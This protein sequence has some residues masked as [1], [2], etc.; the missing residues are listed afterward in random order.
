L[1]YAIGNGLRVGEGAVGFAFSD[2]ASHRP[3]RLPWIVEAELARVDKKG[4]ATALIAKKT[5]YIGTEKLDDLRGQRFLVSGHP[6]FYKVSLV[7]RKRDGT[8]LARYGEYYRVVAPV[9]AVREA[10]IP[11]EVVPGETVYFR[12]ENLGTEGV[13]VDGSAL[14]EQL[15]EGRW[16]E[17]SSVIAEGLHAGIK[18][19]LSGG[20]IAPCFRYSVPPDQQ[21][22]E[23]RLRALVTPLSTRRERG[24]AAEYQVGPRGPVRK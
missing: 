11:T 4:K 21:P 3:R 13:F 7:I 10:V 2:Q 14:I 6:A 19:R 17:V 12:V 15:V 20:E 8:K 18:S 9:L 5:E 1:L 16:T 23:F 24:V 22:G